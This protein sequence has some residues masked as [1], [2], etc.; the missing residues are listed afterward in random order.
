M[1]PV[2]FALRDF[3]VVFGATA[4]FT[5]VAIAL[6]FALDYQNLKASPE[7]LFWLNVRNDILGP[8]IIGAPTFLL[9]FWKLREATLLRRVLERLAFTDSLTGI[10]NRRAFYKAV[11]TALDGNAPPPATMLVIDVDHFKMIN[12]NHGHDVGDQALIALVEA[13]GGCLRETE[14]FGRLGGE[15]FAVFMRGQTPEVAALHAEQLRLA[16]EGCAFGKDRLGG[17]FTAS[18]GVAH[19]DGPTTCAELYR[20][21]DHCLYDAKKAGR[22]CV[23]SSGGSR[24]SLIDERARLTAIA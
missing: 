4:L 14:I 21:A 8:I 12:D 7:E 22:N 2:T 17:H 19:A 3:F 18:I 20:K 1:K 16:I 9:L 10:L 24:R 13:V 15:E 6:V 5:L 23:A 11:E